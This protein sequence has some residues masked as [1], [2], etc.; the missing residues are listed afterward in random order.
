MHVHEN[1]ISC[2]KY[3]LNTNKL[4]YVHKY[5]HRKL[6]NLKSS[7]KEKGHQIIKIDAKH[8]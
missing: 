8:Q 7:F 5:L 2:I 1:Q 3:D 6:H 4:M